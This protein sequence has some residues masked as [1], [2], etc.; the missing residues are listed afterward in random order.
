MKKNFIYK[1]CLVSEWTEAKKKLAFY[2]TKKDIVDGYI[3]FSNK[4]QVKLTLK[5]YFL[6]Q[7]QLVLLKVKVSNLKHL[8]WEE[9]TNGILFPHLYSFLDIKHVKNIYK[10]TL[11]K[12]GS[13][14]LPNFF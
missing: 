12:N 11:T 8:I 4:N 7:D 3:H 9:S 13:H 6:N 10:I 5:K 1:I 2:G 14:I